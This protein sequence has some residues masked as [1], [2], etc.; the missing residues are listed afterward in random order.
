MEN[1]KIE[2]RVVIKFL[3]KEG[4]SSQHIHE[5]LVNAYQ[6]QSPSYTA[7]KK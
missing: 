6:D 3:T 4:V 1:L 2:Y 5:R 7:V